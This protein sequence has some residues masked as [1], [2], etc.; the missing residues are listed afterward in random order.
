[1]FEFYLYE[2]GVRESEE[3]AAGA[4]MERFM[5]V[6]WD[7]EVL[8]AQEDGDQGKVIGYLMIRAYCEERADDAIICTLIETTD[9][10]GY[11]EN[12]PS[13]I[14]GQS[15]PGSECSRSFEGI[16]PFQSPRHFNS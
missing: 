16:K 3:V 8:R 13:Q 7:Q 9:F 4:A 11:P 1:M 6:D 12:H 2:I 14:G 5:R 10:A 15:S